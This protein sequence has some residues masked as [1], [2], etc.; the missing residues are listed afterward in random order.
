MSPADQIP[1]N[2]G[3]LLSPFKGEWVTLSHDEKRVLGHG[4]D[5]NDAL[6]QARD[7]GEDRPILIK[8]PD[9]HSIFLL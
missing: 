4:N 2:L 3:K 5:I 7:K 9:E 1:I 8:A 6:R